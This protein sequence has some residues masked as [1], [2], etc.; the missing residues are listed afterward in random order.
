MENGTFF[1]TGKNKTINK[2]KSS[3]N[4]VPDPVLGIEDM[5]VIVYNFLLEN[6][7]FVDAFVD[8]IRRVLSD[9]KASNF[10]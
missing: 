9:I 4:Y 2:Y 8:G 7:Y 5:V 6:R 1:C 10:S 3:A